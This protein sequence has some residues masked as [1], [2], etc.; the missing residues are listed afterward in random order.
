MKK[1]AVLAAAAVSLPLFSEFAVIGGEEFPAERIDFAKVGG[2]S[3][4]CRK[5]GVAESVG[6]SNLVAWAKSH[7]LDAF[8][9]GSPWTL[10]SQEVY[11]RNERE[12]RDL[13]YGGKKAA[14][15]AVLT[16]VAGTERILKELN[17]ED[18]GTLYYV[19]NETP[20]SFFGHLW[21]I[22]FRQVVPAWHDYSQDRP[23]WYS[24]YD[25]GTAERNAVTGGYQV[26]RTYAIVVA[27]Q[28]AF[29]ALAIWAHPTSWWTRDGKNLG[30]FVTNIATEMIPQMMIDG[31]LDGMTV[32]GYDPY[33][34]DYQNLWFALLDLGYR[35]PGFAELDL[36]PTHGIGTK[37]TMLFNYLP[38]PKR[39][40]TVE[41][42]KADCKA[43]RHT[44]SSGP[45]LLMKVDGRL[46]GDELESGAGRVHAVEVF[47]WPK[48]TE[49]E[50]SRVQLLGRGGRILAEKRHV[51][52]G[53]IAW[54]VAG[55]AAGGYLVARAFGEKDGDYAEK[56][57]QQTRQCAL[58]N[59][60][61]LRTD[62][63]RAP[64]PIPAPDP[65]TIPE[66]R[67]LEDFLLKGEF[68]FD[69]RVTK[70]LEPGMVPV[71]AFQ[72]DAVR[73]A[74]QKAAAAR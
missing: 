47:A 9:V 59:P 18:G 68:R 43:A 52:G 15:M 36:S 62:A 27:E 53:R 3:H 50:L 4:M 17:A 44:M 46:Q 10:A 49:G 7:G 28:R 31:F 56:P 63:F 58:T 21:Y 38:Y 57:Q 8:G 23:C 11:R 2:H 12:D 5:G 54:T 25:D 39:P 6:K 20:K 41:R 67:K 55:D 48:A 70:E 72:I 69:P 40:L 42:I 30:P 74:L 35:V 66:V 61:W 65:M 16:D 60:V 37:D 51:K 73:A 22:G 64:A 32:M 34:P 19:D 13:Y 1:I 33:H 26:R 14:E 45:H 71:W 29:G 24:A